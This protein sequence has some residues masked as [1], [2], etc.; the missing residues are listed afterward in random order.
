M[1]MNIKITNCLALC[2]CVMLAL[3][4]CQ[5]IYA[6]ETQVITNVVTFTRVPSFSSDHIA[7][8]IKN[9]TDRALKLDRHI[10]ASFGVPEVDAE[11]PPKS[12]RAGV[13]EV[14]ASFILPKNEFATLNGSGNRSQLVEIA[15][16]QETE[17]KLYINESYKIV[18]SRS[19]KVILQ[20]LLDDKVIS[21]TTFTKTDGTWKQ[22]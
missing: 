9:P 2:C 8:T 13:I 1:R 12:T 15:A 3:I 18:A 22:N 11:P 10:Y 5:S 20:L 6:D 19:R 14:F 17:L 4:A 21:S 16:H 7:L